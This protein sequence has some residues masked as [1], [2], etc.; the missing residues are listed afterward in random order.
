M[1][2]YINIYIYVYIYKY[3]FQETE[4]EICT[5][6]YVYIHVYI[7]IYICIHFS[8]GRREDIS[9]KS[10]EG[11]SVKTGEKISISRGEE[12]S[13]NRGVD[14]SV[15]SFECYAFIILLLSFSVHLS[16]CHYVYM[17]FF[18]FRLCSFRLPP[19]T[20][21]THKH[22][23]PCI[24]RAFRSGFQTETE[25]GFVPVTLNV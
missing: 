6:M 2:I 1:Y 14:I 25:T 3:I 12:I 17:S 22:T 24:L 15:H 11:I 20:L 19:P 13:M 8:T 7:Y 18:E 16:V 21:P 9:V 10:G 5:H 4:A 23:N